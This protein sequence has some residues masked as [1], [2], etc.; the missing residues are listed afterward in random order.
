MLFA[1]ACNFLVMGDEAAYQM[2]QLKASMSNKATKVHFHSG[3][4]GL[5]VCVLT[6]DFCMRSQLKNMTSGF[7]SDLQTRYS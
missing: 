7:F 5:P 6:F 4:A 3:D 2:Q 1:C